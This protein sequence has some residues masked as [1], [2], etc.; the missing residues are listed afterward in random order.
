MSSVP[1]ENWDDDFEFG[2]S[3]SHNN[4]KPKDARKPESTISSPLEPRP[5]VASSHFSEDWDADA[6]SRHPSPKAPVAGS[7]RAGGTSSIGSRLN[8]WAEPGPSTPTKHGSTQAQAEN[9]DDDFED[10]ADSPP[11]RRHHAHR[12]SHHTFQHHHHP[13]ALRTRH[14]YHTPP[15]P[16]PPTEPENWDDDFDDPMDPTSSTSP[17]KSDH[18]N[19][20]MTKRTRREAYTDSSDED[21][22]LDLGFSDDKEEDKTVTAR[23]RTAPILRG[24]SSNS[25]SHASSYHS[26]PP[27]L[28]ALPHALSPSPI[29]PFPRSPTVSV[30][31][32]PTTSGRNSIGYFNSTSHLVLSRATS[33]LAMLPPSPPTQRERRRLRKKS[34]PPHMDNN[35][36]ELIEEHRDS[37]SPPLP[38]STPE[39][40]RA[41]SPPTVPMM[42][43][44]SVEAT[45][46]S[47]GS[48]TP[49]L[50]RIG[51]VKKWGVRRKR[52]STGPGEVMMQEFSTSSGGVVEDERTPRPPSSLEQTQ[53]QTPSRNRNSNNAGET[54]P[55]WFFRPGGAHY[56]TGSPSP[57][58]A[59]LKH[60]KSLDQA[61]LRPGTGGG[62]SEGG[63]QVP[64]TPSKNGKLSKWK[65]SGVPIKYTSSGELT[66]DGSSS[67]SGVVGL[68]KPSLGPSRRPTSM[69]V[70]NG[71]TLG[72]GTGSNKFASVGTRHASYG[73]SIGRAS[74][75]RVFSTPTPSESVEDLPPIPA[76]LL[77]EGSRSLIGSVRKISI[78][79]GKKHKKNKSSVDVA[80]IP[81][82]PAT[83]IQGDAGDDEGRDHDADGDARMRTPP[84]ACTSDLL[85]PIELHPPSPPRPI[86][87]V[88]M[89][90]SIP[91]S[92]SDGTELMIPSMSAPA[93]IT[94]SP[95]VSSASPVASNKATPKTPSSPQSASL[96]RT[97]QPPNPPPL[98]ASVPRRNSLGDLK[99]PARI[100]QA[101]IG[102][103]R[104]LGMVR[105]FAIS[106]DRL[107]ELQTTY[108]HLLAEVQTFLESTPP[109]RATSPNMF[110]LVHPRS[111]QRSNISPTN[112][113][114]NL[115]GSFSEHKHI[116]TT[117]HAITVKYKISW[118][119]AELLIELG[120]GAP[121]PAFP[122]AS[123]PSSS[124][125]AP[126]VSMQVELDRRKN[127]ERAVTLSGE[128]SKQPPVAL[129]NSATASIPSS[130]PGPPTA[131]WRASTGRHDLSQRQLVLLR[132][133]LSSGE[134]PPDDVPLLEENVNRN[135]RWGDAMSSTVTLPSEESGSRDA[136]RGEGAKKKRRGGRMGLTGLRDVL[137]MLKWSH[138]EQ[139]ATSPVP[140][141]PAVPSTT[142]LSTESSHYSH[143]Y[144][145]E[146]LVADGAHRASKTSTRPE[147]VRS[148]KDTSV[149]SPHSGPPLN[150]KSSPRRPSLA[151]IFRLGQKNKGGASSST[152]ESSQD[153]RSDVRSASRGSNMTGEEED[154]DRIE[155][156]IDLDGAARALGIEGTATIRG[157][158]ARMSPFLSEYS[159]GHAP[160][161]THRPVTPRRV[162]ETTQILRLEVEASPRSIRPMRS[163]RLSNVEEVEDGERQVPSEGKSK[164]RV[165]LPRTS[166]H[167]PPSRG[168]MPGSSRMGSVR[169]AL[170]QPLDDPPALPEIKLSMTPENIKPLLENA[171]EVHVRCHECI[172]ELRALLDVILAG[173]SSTI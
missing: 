94:M 100:S 9:W 141:I 161:P 23:S 48:K 24:G 25:H 77:Q 101:Q 44:S 42:P 34:R 111:R 45:P 126:T 154:W 165:S 29:E 38:P 130:T 51:S 32:I 50:S 59:E 148:T 33:S 146:Q 57:G 109:S 63:A 98:N 115:P 31:S 47:G 40:E 123:G 89:T 106:V 160:G 162:Q 163:T 72:I 90:R 70:S 14:S 82:V 143:H 140:A 69:Q 138:A 125:L 85:P 81:P 133:M 147:S 60:E 7:G 86:N 41:S 99:I 137:R 55:T 11:G 95:I 6:G 159:P 39:R 68:G 73:S 158:K 144:P 78:V 127:R 139:T 104:D 80:Y 64:T 134:L 53:A 124:L 172:R 169:S 114:S 167:R 131:S 76:L 155:A 28:P 37:S 12:A 93:S 121:S 13:H 8:N 166:P 46:R 91:L 71:A 79:G 66:G 74:S 83:S 67:A 110:S 52:A 16:K 3:S 2:H 15:R 156:A 157:R 171:K 56:G 149:N 102:L 21:D 62:R 107:K 1:S 164:N 10:K 88:S 120:G 18:D 142:S 22:D 153:S 150:H 103:K 65:A 152:G 108:R 30:F 43:T 113:S 105:E 170:P 17:S 118:E 75:S 132:D 4:S 112:T 96:G 35:V 20:P 151:S 129:I 5:S 54:R 36:F 173:V 128:E 135:W 145:H 122:P 26:P 61:R 92:I 116:A 49:L 168:Q 117:L 84:P 27:P 136:D 58:H 119:C 19:T 87:G 97:A